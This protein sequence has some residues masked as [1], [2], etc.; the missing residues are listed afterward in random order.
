MLSEYSTDQVKK[1][2]ELFFR[3]NQIKISIYK[4]E[5][6]L[7]SCHSLIHFNMAVKTL[8]W[9]LELVAKLL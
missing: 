6:N 7:K 3:V 2:S 8:T 5:K 1:N 4:K 9:N